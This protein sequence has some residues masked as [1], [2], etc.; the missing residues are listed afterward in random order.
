[1]QISRVLS[2]KFRFYTFV[3]IVLLLFVHGYNLQETYL[4]PFSTV[5][6]PLTFTAFFEY[7]VSNGLLRFRIPLLFMISGYIYALQDNKPYWER[8]KKR[9]MT[10]LVPYLLW[11][12]LGLLL[13]FVLQRNAYTYQ[14]VLAAQLDQ[15]GDNRIYEEVGW[16]GVMERWLLAPVSF[17]LWFIIALFMYNLMYP[18]IRWM[19][20]RYPWIWIGITAFLWLS[21]FNF[22]FIGGQGLFFFSLGVYLQ[23]ANFNIE[24][25][26]KWLSLYICFLVYVA[27]SVIKSFMAFELDPESVNTFIALHMLHSITI[28]SGIVAIWYG[29]DVVVKWC[30]QQQWFIWLSGFAF[31]IY[32]FH[33][34]MISFLT[35]W[36]FSILDGFTYYRLLTYFLTP[37]IILAICVGVGLLLKKISPPTFRLLTGGRGL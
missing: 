28:V 3:C 4:T 29:A 34:P 32:G 17:Q 2:Q 35:R 30:I 6:E 7:L 10:L 33:A 12:A 13:T 23:K 11:S 1:M 25:K 16:W 14:F 21:Y 26:P 27:S 20:V 18:F 15:L 8:T 5:K 19:V 37:A 36:L 22:I 24:R 9:V 31:F